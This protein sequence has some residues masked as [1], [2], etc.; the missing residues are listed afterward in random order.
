M[1]TLFS[2][3]MEPAGY[4]VLAANEAEKSSNITLIEV[5]PF[6]GSGRIY[7]GGTEADSIWR[8]RK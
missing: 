5:R 2:L 1:D 4:A 3:E 7:L 8:W 6:G